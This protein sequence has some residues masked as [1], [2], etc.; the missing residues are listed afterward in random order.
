MTGARSM[1][2]V[3]AAVLM[4][5][6]AAAGEREPRSAFEGGTLG[7]TVE[8]D[9]FGGTDANYTSGVRVDWL[10]GRN[11]LPLWGR[12]A[13]EGLGWLTDAGDWYVGYGIG[14]S[15]YTPA[16]ISRRVPDPDDR[17]Y[18][19]FLYGSLAV[20]AD[21]GDQLDTVALDLGVV[22]PASQAE[23][24]QR[25]VHRITG[26]TTPRGWDAQLRNEPG[27]RLLW[28]RKYRFLE[29]IDTG[30][31]GLQVD[32]VPH[33]NVA[34]GNVDTSAAFGG[35]VRIGDRLDDTYGPTR[36]RPAVSGPGFFD[37]SDGF[38]W[39]LFASAE[40]RV[41]G[42]NIFLQGNAFRNGVDGVEPN[43][44]VGDFQAGLA[45]QLR[46]A[47]LSYTHVLRSEEFDGQDGFGSFGSVNLRFRF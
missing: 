18:A 46:R 10:S 1:S 13:R 40:A 14:Q 20:V 28:E 5:V 41:V 33:V 17:P 25:F 21:G 47:E 3:F 9:R 26:A 22:G 8:N 39:Y 31:F 35:T 45:L 15:I 32:A 4:S 19:G 44:I 2:A 30:L 36:I 24:T 23:E 29:T 38:G 42:Y 34:V 43:R 37:G 27:F 12:M 11:D 7:V 16:D 6:S